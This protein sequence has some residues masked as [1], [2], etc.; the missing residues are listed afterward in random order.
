MYLV[1][2]MFECSIISNPNEWI[3]SGMVIMDKHQSYAIN[4]YLSTWPEEWS[5]NQII[6]EMASGDQGAMIS[7]CEDYEGIP[8][9]DIAIMIEDMVKTLKAIF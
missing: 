2:N 8:I 7:E 1:E 4:H 5:Y 9:D 3:F 6:A